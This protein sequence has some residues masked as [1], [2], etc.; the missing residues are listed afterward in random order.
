MN[1]IPFIAEKLGVKIG[2]KFKIGD[3][4][5]YLH[6]FGLMGPDDCQYSTS[7]VNLL[8]GK[9][10]ITKIPFRPKIGEDY[11]YISKMSVKMDTSPLIE[12][13]IKVNLS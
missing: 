4:I 9:N 11:I 2:E 6:E 7:L 12:T 13:L 10:K 1:L 5:F 3:D 8:I